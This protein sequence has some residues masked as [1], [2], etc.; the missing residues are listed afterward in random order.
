MKLKVTVNGTAYEVQV[1]VEQEPP[2]TLGGF[3]FGGGARAPMVAHTAPVHL[4]APAHEEKVLRAPVSGTVT[5]VNVEVGQAVEAGM[6][7]IMLEAMKMETEIT[8]PTD[9][10]IAEVTVHSGEAVTG[11]Q[12]LVRWE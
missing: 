7:L 1:E 5:K 8:A 2:P 12:V 3:V 6:T 11:G 9:G 10:K 4:R